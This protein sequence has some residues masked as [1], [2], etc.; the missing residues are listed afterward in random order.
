MGVPS[1]VRD[2]IV[3][4]QVGDVYAAVLTAPYVW[5]SPADAVDVTAMGE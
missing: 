2:R 3:S 5:A 1:G 4:A